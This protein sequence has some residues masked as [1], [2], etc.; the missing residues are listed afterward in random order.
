MLTYQHHGPAPSNRRSSISNADERKHY[1]LTLKYLNKQFP[2]LL[3]NTYQ[4]K[5]LNRF[6]PWV[7]LKWGLGAVSI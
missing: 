2:P 7:E 6:N 5:Q 3:G 4:V 1:N